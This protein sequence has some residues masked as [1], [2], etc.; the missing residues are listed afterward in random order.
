MRWPPVLS[1]GGA[2][3]TP[4]AAALAVFEDRVKDAQAARAAFTTLRQ[5]VEAFNKSHSGR[6]PAIRTQL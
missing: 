3:Y 6:L 4:A 5:E 2:G 1:T